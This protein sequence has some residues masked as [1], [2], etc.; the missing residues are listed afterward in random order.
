MRRM[1]KGIAEDCNRS[2]ACVANIFMSWS[3]KREELFER[4]KSFHDCGLMGEMV[5]SLDSL[6]RQG[7]RVV[8]SKR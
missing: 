4:E 3:G 1:M 2:P 5:G 6:W 8:R 7:S